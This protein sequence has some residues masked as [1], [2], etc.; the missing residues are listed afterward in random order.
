MY[1][2]NINFTNYDDDKPTP[3]IPEAFPPCI[4]KA[5][6]GINSGG[7]NYC[8]NMILT[9]FLSYARLYPGVYA[10]HIKDAKV[11]DMDPTLKITRDEIMP[12]IHEAAQNCTPPLFNDQPEEKHNINSKL[13][14]G[15]NSISHENCGK[16]PWYTPSNCQ[17]IKQQS[18]LCVPCGDCQKIGNPLIILQQKKKTDNKKQEKRGRC[19]LRKQQRMK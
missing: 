12:L 19:N 13:G 4:K 18:N 17:N 2:K 9:P 14:F 1:S 16:T 7:R 5:L 15:E 8:I 10:R 11:T 3:Y 6:R